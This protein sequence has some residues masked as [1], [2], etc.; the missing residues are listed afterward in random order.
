MLGWLSTQWQS[1]TCAIDKKKLG[2]ANGTKWLQ[3]L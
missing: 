2:E 3:A 1:K